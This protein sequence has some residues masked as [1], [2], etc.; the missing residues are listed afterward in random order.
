MFQ[1]LCGTDALQNVILATTMWDLVDEKTGNEREEELRTRYWRSMIDFGSQVARFRNTYESAWEIVRR[2]KGRPQVLPCDRFYRRNVLRRMSAA[3]MENLV[4]YV[5]SF[6]V[7]LCN[8]PNRRK[9]E[10]E[11][12]GE[13]KHATARPN[14][15]K[16]KFV[17]LPKIM[18]G[19]SSTAVARPSSTSLVTRSGTIPRISRS[20]E[21]HSAS[22]VETH[23]DPLLPPVVGGHQTPRVLGHRGQELIANIYALQNE[24]HISTVPFLK[25]GVQQIIAIAKSINVCPFLSLNDVGIN[26][27]NL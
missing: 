4:G 22:K 14:E 7:R 20:P 3:L 23:Y 1:K 12:N 15:Q 10:D 8:L 24:R 19:R 16:R 2:F 17:S 11:A 26:S 6:K 5:H 27:S 9:R 25:S 13:C 18:T 21:P